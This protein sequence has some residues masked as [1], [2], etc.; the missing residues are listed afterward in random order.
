MV[1]EDVPAEYLIADGLD[2]LNSVLD[3]L[4]AQSQQDGP[5]ATE[6]HYILYRNGDQRSLIKVDTSHQ[7]FKFWYADLN[8]RPATQGVKRTIAT[9]LWD[10]CGAK[11]QYS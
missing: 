6:P 11:E 7:P 1:N 5:F 8:G 10:K 9:F 3:S 2:G 4:L